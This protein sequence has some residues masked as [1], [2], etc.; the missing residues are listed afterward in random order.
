MIALRGQEFNL[1]AF[2]AFRYALGRQTYIVRDT[3]ELLARQRDHLTDS[4]RSLMVREI[5][6]AVD[7]GRAGGR[8]DARMWLRLKE[9]LIEPN[10]PIDD[11]L[12]LL[13]EM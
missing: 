5:Q 2:S 3:V 10:E 7:A 4:R 11:L 8:G 1:L 9:K 12:D 6:E 13:Q